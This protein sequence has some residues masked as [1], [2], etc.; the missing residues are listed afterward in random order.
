MNFK[1]SGF[2]TPSFEIH[3]AAESFSPKE[4]PKI[5]QS[6]VIEIYQGSRRAKK[7]ILS[8]W[9]L[10][11]LCKF[12]G[13]I[14][15]EKLSTAKWISQRRVEIPIP[16]KFITLWFASPSNMGP[17]NL[18][19]RD[20]VFRRTRWALDWVQTLPCS[21]IAV[22]YDRPSIMGEGSAA[23]FLPKK[24]GPHMVRLC[25][26]TIYVTIYCWIH[27]WIRRMGA[28]P[29]SK[30]STPDC[31]KVGAYTGRRSL[32]RPSLCNWW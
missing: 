30:R 3:I 20:Y 9:V 16:S 19:S 25:Y 17:K 31:Q 5:V 22:V 32:R 29:K 6:R 2:F 11:R 26:G 13:P 10:S 27:F 7:L 24:S 15:G 18:H 23:V 12:F 1:G 21:T 4:V 14:F 8:D 28:F